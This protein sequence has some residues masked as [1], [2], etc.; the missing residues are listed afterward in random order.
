MF[1]FETTDETPLEA[2]C[3]QVASQLIAR[4]RWRLM[5][6]DELARR[7][8]EELS[9]RVDLDGEQLIERLMTALYV[10]ALHGACSRTEGDRRWEIGYG[11]LSAYL[12]GV[13]RAKYP[14]VAEDA[15]ATALLATLEKFNDCRNPRAFLLFALQRL[16]TCVRRLRRQEV[17][18]GL[19]LDQPAHED[20]E[21]PLGERIE[22][23]AAGPAERTANGELAAE[24]GRAATEFRAAHPRARD[25]FAALYL[26]YIEDLS[27]GEIAERLGTTIAN[28]HVLRSR[29]KQRLRHDPAWQQLAAEAEGALEH[30]GGEA[31]S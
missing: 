8:A 30:R 25:Q 29:A 6:A 12:H 3:R 7:A 14:D 17:P 4:N 5:A 16:W 26:K 22:D 19:S 27:D 9:C 10:E 11:E 1:A 13:A 18:R 21:S 24:V 23:T 28:V 20:G 15:A 31:A 2:Y